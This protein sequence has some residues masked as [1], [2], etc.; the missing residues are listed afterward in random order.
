MR[1]AHAIGQAQV[2]VF[3]PVRVGLMIAGFEVP[4]CHVHVVPT[5][6]M[7]DL[8]FANAAA[9]TRSGRAGRCRRS[10]AR[11]LRAAGHDEVV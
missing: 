3:S 8:D 4:H 7:A 11:G 10:A 9:A 2:E 5:R 6:S 1:V